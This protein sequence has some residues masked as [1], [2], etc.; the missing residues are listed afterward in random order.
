[1]RAAISSTPVANIDD[2]FTPP[3][4]P[5]S[6]SSPTAALLKPSPSGGGGGSHC[7]SI[8]SSSPSVTH[9]APPSV[10]VSAEGSPDGDALS[11]VTV[12]KM[13][14]A[15]GVPG[16]RRNGN[17]HVAPCAGHKL[18]QQQQQEKEQQQQQQRRHKGHQR[19]WLSD[20]Q[21]ETD[22]EFLR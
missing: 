5:L 1:M 6:S 19:Q 21:G 13:A 20:H 8:L 14:D 22:G 17:H 12:R 3:A 4:T 11:D 10:S 15:E 7:T 2:E 16:D 18:V 9:D